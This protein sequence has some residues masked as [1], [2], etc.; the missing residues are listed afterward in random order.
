MSLPIVAQSGPY[1]SAGNEE[2]GL[3]PALDAKR[4]DYSDPFVFGPE[5]AIDTLQG[6]NI[7]PK[8]WAF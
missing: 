4:V 5:F 7:S 6:T 3:T 1:L 8:K 2:N